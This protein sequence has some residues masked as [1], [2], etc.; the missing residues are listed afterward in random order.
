MI[1]TLIL[2]MVAALVLLVAVKL[3]GGDP[4]GTDATSGYLRAFGATAALTILG[5]LVSQANIWIL[6]LLWPI[7]WLWLLKSIY[8]FTWTRAILVWLAI[9]VISFITTMIL[10]S[11]QLIDG[12]MANILPGQMT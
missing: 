10:K 6:N 11:F 4:R 3:T 5:W 1:G 9:V 8:G 12:G 7:L 2:W